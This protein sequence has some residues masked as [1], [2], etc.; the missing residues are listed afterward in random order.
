MELGLNKCD[1]DVKKCKDF[2]LASRY[3]PPFNA[4][5]RLVTLTSLAVLRVGLTTVK[6][7]FSAVNAH[8]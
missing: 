7:M 2:P 4:V 1:N 8:I 3:Q 5:L 6:G